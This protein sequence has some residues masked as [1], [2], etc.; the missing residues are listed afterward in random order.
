MSAPRPAVDTA[1][2]QIEA[3]LGQALPPFAAGDLD[4]FAAA[5]GGD[6]H[7]L[8]RWLKRRT[9]GEALAHIVGGFEF[10]GRRFAIDKR[11]YVTDAE[12]THLIDALLRRARGHLDITGRPPLLAEIGV[13][14][15]SLA[16]TL[17]AE[18][19]AALV[20]GLD[21]DPDALAVAA[22][23]AARLGLPVRLVES[24]LLDDW[25]DDLPAP[26]FIYGDPPWGDATTLYEADRP[27][28]HYRTM[29]PASSFPLGGRTGVHAQILRAVQA[30]GWAS[31]I[32]LNGGVLPPA[33]L[34]ALA[35]GAATWAVVTPRP[36]L[37]LLRCQMTVSK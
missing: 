14:C 6:V 34:A 16:L 36:G 17:K 19:P 4:A 32:W 18:L 25:P 8:K 24:D 33:E 27:I 30:R 21:L 29:P 15:G 26:D 2:A 13:G 3:E 12:V 1:L 11:A 35:A 5:A 20:V 31:E 10:R 28:S 23:N 22:A 9:A 37:S 7:R